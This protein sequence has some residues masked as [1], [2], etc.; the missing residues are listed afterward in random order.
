MLRA[1][2]EPIVENVK[3]I[4]RDYSHII[5]VHN[6]GLTP[7]DSDNVRN[8][9]RSNKSGIRVV[10]NSLAERAFKDTKHERMATMFNGPTAI[11]YANDIVSLAKSAAEFAKKYDAKLVIIGGSME[12]EVIDASAV[13]KLATLPSLEVLHGKLVGLISAPAQRLVGVL[14]APASQLARVCQAYA[15]K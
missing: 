4:A 8:A 9:L 3:R 12:G 15:T 13:K 14:S 5:V 10:K 11:M 6:K 7:A 1:Q 2:K